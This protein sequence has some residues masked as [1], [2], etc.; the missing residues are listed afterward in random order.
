MLRCPLP[1][2]CAPSF[3]TRR[4]SFYCSP[5]SMVAPTSCRNIAVSPRSGEPGNDAAHLL[6]PAPS[7]RHPGRPYLLLPQPPLPLAMASVCSPAEVHIPGAPPRARCHPYGSTVSSYFPSPSSRLA[8]VSLASSPTSSGR[9]RQPRRRRFRPSQFALLTNG[10]DST[11]ALECTRLRA[12]WSPERGRRG[13]VVGVP[14][15]S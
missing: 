13:S 14:P 15:R 1:P 8:R 6:L 7:S 9:R 3:P 2:P 11:P 4:I 12:K 5:P 10:C